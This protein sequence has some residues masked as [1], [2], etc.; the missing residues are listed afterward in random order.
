MAAIRLW[1]LFCIIGV[2]TAQGASVANEFLRYVYGAEDV[3]LAKVCWPHDD[4]WM[5][6][7][8]P[9]PAGL[10]ELAATN[11]RHKD[12]DIVWE[13]IANDLCIVEV[14]DGKVV[15]TFLLEQVYTLHR[16]LVLRFLYASLEQDLKNLERLSTDAAKI[17][18]G[19]A[20]PQPGGDM[21]VY[22]EIIACLPV[23]RVSASADDKKSKNVTYR[24][25]L[26]RKGFTLQLVKKG[27]TWLVDSHAGIDVP[28][29]FFFQ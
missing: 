23:V 5:L 28:L 9:N 22:G 10:A 26:G 25:P 21:D 6:R 20:K 16:Q 3:D 24:V 11:I 29:E 15:P 8:A 7:G 27:S 1:V 13:S 18:F 12:N 17:R 19:G 14:R 2:A 4:L